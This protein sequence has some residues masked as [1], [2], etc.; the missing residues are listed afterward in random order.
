MGS[1]RANIR[2][3]SSDVLATN[4]DISSATT[5]TA[6][7]GNINRLKVLAT[8][9]GDAS[10]QT[11]HKANEKLNR[12]YLY[13]KNLGTEAEKY[14]YVFADTSSDDPV[15]AKLGGG[16]FC[17]VPVDPAVNLKIYATDVDQI[18]EYAVFGLDSSAVR[19]S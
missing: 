1:V 2:I 8:A 18:V 3:S 9:K 19:Y 10:V 12:A 16:E 13:V 4:V 11:I 7:S 15:V 17:F 5:I 6:D 14:A